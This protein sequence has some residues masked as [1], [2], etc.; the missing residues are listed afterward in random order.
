MGGS[1]ISLEIRAGLGSSLLLWLPLPLPPPIYPDEDD[2]DGRPTDGT[3]TGDALVPMMAAFQGARFVRFAACFLA[4]AADGVVTISS[5]LF[6]PPVPLLPSYIALKKRDF[7]LAV[8]CVDGVGARP[9]RGGDG[10]S[11]PGRDTREGQR[12]CEL[13]GVTFEVARAEIRTSKEKLRNFY[14]AGSGTARV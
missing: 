4:G 2:G 7:P 5:I 9:L 10:A 12:E 1:E 13:R 8:R 6:P 3:G 11:G 14:L